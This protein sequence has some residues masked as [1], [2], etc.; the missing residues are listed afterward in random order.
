MSQPQERVLTQVAFV[1]EDI[2]ST[3]HHWI[4][5]M[6][7]GPWQWMENIPLREVTY[8]GQPAELELSAAVA[9]S[10]SVQIELIT[11]HNDGP[12]AYRDVVRDGSNGFHHICVFPKDY[13]A[14]VARYEKMGCEM[15]TGGVVDASDLRFCYMDARDKLNCMVEIVDN[16]AG[17]LVVWADLIKATEEW[18]GKTDPI[19]RIPLG[20][21]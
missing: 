18:D 9:F 20:A 5:V 13:D 11:Q 1:V 15:A 8:R 10:G 21:I 12:S 3:I 17:H 19:R 6:G 16:P 4:D 2:E 7:I 14:E